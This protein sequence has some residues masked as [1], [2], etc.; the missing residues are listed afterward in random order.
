VHRQGDVIGAY[1]SFDGRD[2]Y[3]MSGTDL[4]VDGVLTV[5]ENFQSGQFGIRLIEEASYANGLSDVP[6]SFGDNADTF[7]SGGGSGNLLLHMGGGDDYV[8][9]SRN[10][11][12]VFGEAGNDTVFGNS[13][14]DRLYGGMGNDVLAGDN[15]DTSVID[16]DDLLDGGDGD[17]Y[18]VGGWGNDLLYGGAGT[19]TLYGD[20]TGKAQGSYSADDYLDGGDGNDEL[21]GLAGNDVLFGG[22]GNDF[23]SGEEGDDNESG[24][25][26]D[27]SILAYTGNDTLSG[28]AGVDKL[29]G[30]VGDDILDGGSENDELYG[31]DGNDTLFGGSGDDLLRGDFVNNPTHDS[32]AGGNDFLDGEDGNDQLSGGIGD[33][34]VFGGAGNDLVLGEEGADSLFGD[35]GDDELQGGDGNDLL[36]G[37]AG[38]DT[39]FGQDGNDTVYGDDG[40][41]YLEGGTGD[42]VL[43]GGAGN[44]TYFF[45]SGDGHDVITDTPSLGAGNTIRFGSGISLSNLTLLQNQAV[46]TLTIQVAGTADTIQLQGLDLNGVTGT[47]VVQTLAFA[48]GSQVLLTDLLPLPDGFVEGSDNNDFLRTGPGDDLLDAGSGDD[49]L[50]AGAGNDTLLGGVGNDTLLGGAGN[51]VYVFN[52][53]D[54]ADTIQDV[55]IADEAN[56]LSFGV[57]KEAVTLAMSGNG[58]VLHVGSGGDTITLSNFNPTDAYGTHAVESFQF[59][60][61]ASLNYQQLL[62]RG[63]DFNGTDGDDLLTGTSAFDR[64]IGH[65]SDD[66]YMVANANDQVIELSGEGTDTVEATDSYTL[67][68]NVENLLGLVTDAMGD[69]GPASLIGNDLD[70]EIS[71]PRGIASDNVLEGRG[72][73]DRLFSYEGNDRLDGGVGDDTLE[74]GQGNDIYVFGLGYGHDTV[75]EQPFP[76]DMNT[77]ALTS[78]VAPDDVVLMARQSDALLDLVLSMNGGADELVLRAALE[79]DPLPFGEI[80]FADGTVWDTPTILSHIQ[81]AELTA[82]TDGSTLFGTRF[83]DQLTGLQGDDYLDGEEGPDVMAGGAGNDQYWV[84]NLGDAVIEAAG[85]GT[86]VVGSTIDYTLPANVENLSLSDALDRPAPVVGIGNEL[87]NVIRGNLVTIFSR[88]EPK[89]TRCGAEISMSRWV[90]VMMI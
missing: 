51:D 12:Q 75:F 85:E 73:N 62:E 82:S 86:D 52:E 89:M 5:N 27:D 34:I 38:N 87:D 23:L 61:G 59:A 80:T 84:D 7:A 11:D 54:E 1:T 16:G 66:T 15:D 32:L 31:G 36:T 68:D 79:Y 90:L 60:D 74:G 76:G 26:G 3:V 35:D 25:D 64:F 41:D 78:G 18:L 40:A 47:S 43:D 24:G 22:A 33:D 53:G 2:T 77:I 8:L 69:S 4:V 88:V 58:L 39:L 48:D 67:P 50:D 19:D 45:A 37:D 13:A 81:G 44:D 57:S 20:T 55:A 63:I 17:D 65:A 6:F 21:H 72:G 14:N 71:G 49:V 42:D 46:S 28:D 29:Y 9:A 30:D 70:N 83:P 56:T 10:N